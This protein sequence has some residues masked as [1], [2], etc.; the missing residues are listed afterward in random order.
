MAGEIQVNSVTAL[1][2]SGSSIVLN[3]VNTATNRTNLGLGSM[4]TQAAN[5]VSITGGTIGSSVVFPAGHVIQVVFAQTT[6]ITGINTATFTDT[7]LSGAITPTS[8]T[9]KILVFI[10]QEVRNAAAN[11]TTLGCRLKLLRGTTDIFDFS[12][13][14]SGAFDTFE[15]TADGGGNVRMSGYISTMYLDSPATTSAT[16]YKT[17]AATNA[18][19]HSFQNSGAPSMMTLMEIS[20]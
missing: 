3:N 12:S 9:S 18:G 5:S 17:Q 13:L 7:S 20:A 6:T 14:A 2:E 4:S 1:T 10:N 15:I 11:P 19:P 8:A 16:T